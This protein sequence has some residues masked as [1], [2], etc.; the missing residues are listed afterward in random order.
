MRPTDWDDG[1]FYSLYKTLYISMSIII[2]ILIIIII[3]T[4]TN[5]I[6][7]GGASIALFGTIVAGGFL[8]FYMY[9]NIGKYVRSSMTK[10]VTGRFKSIG[11]NIMNK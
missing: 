11:S 1:E 6:G 2:V 7:R 9:I 4:L 10:G 5:V 8:T 3:M